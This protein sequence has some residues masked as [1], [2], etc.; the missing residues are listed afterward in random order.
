MSYGPL[1][2]RDLAAAARLLNS[3]FGVE[4]A[5]S[6]RWLHALDNPRA[7]RV[8]D[9]V[10]ATFA[11][12]RTE[13]SFGAW[14]PVSCV[15]GVAV[16]LEARGR[17]HG[18]ALMEGH[19][20]EI[21]AEGV[22]L[23]SLYASTQVLYRSVGYEQAGEALQRSIKASRIPA[24]PRDLEIYEVPL[25][26]DL[27][28]FYEPFALRHPGM[29]RRNPELW[30]RALG[31]RLPEP[32]RLYMLGDEGYICVCGAKE[33]ALV[34]DLVTLSPRALRRAWTLLGDMRSMVSTVGWASHPQDPALLLFGEQSSRVTRSERWFLRI[35][36]VEQALLL[37]R[38]AAD[39][40]LHLHLSD[41][42][43]SE[44][45]GPWLLRV[46][47]GEPSLERG[48]RGDLRLPIRSLAPLYSGLMSAE[49]L[50]AAG[51]AEGR[52]T[53]PL[54]SGP[55]PWMPDSF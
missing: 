11:E 19:L 33:E 46:L 42:L 51:L 39:G 10:V 44:N 16:A 50:L 40:E 28:P 53:P 25:H 1:E 13:M 43:F 45:E 2:N 26:S 55:T 31:Q 22:P 32:R 54:F 21:R 7:I 41:P 15:A 34:S 20:R 4:Q 36:H 47:D 5:D 30:A 14:V 35:V 17:G 29:L 38:Y 48:G 18:R 23:A 49:Q 52:P 6:E 3:A 9:E 8:D 27:R 24:G 12:Y 37:R